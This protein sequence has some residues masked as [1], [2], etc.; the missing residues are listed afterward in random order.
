[1]GEDEVAQRREDFQGLLVRAADGRAP[2]VA[3]RH[4]ETVRE[5]PLVR[6]L[7]VLEEQVLDRVVG[8]HDAHVRV[9]GG[10]GRAEPRTII[11]GFF[12]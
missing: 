4:D 5:G 12:K 9:V 3:A 7:R 11:S 1:M 10:D 2:R 8:E 6:V